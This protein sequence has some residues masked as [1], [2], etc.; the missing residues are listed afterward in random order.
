[1]TQKQKVV[2]T[3][4]VSVAVNWIKGVNNSGNFADIIH[5]LPLSLLAALLRFGLG[6][7]RRGL[8][9]FVVCLWQARRPKRA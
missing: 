6:A 5:E 2:L 4:C 3:S 9:L 7:T 1:M 8:S